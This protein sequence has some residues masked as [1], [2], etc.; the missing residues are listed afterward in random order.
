MSYVIGECESV[1]PLMGAWIEIAIA[2][3]VFATMGVA[4]L[5]GAWIEIIETMKTPVAQKVAPLMGAWIE[6]KKKRH[7]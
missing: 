5:M 1:A 2:K 6:I 4:P 7:P 3:P